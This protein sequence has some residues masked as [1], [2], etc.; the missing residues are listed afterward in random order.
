[1]KRNRLTSYIILLT[2]VLVASC[3]MTKDIPEGDQLFTGLKTIQWV[4]AKQSDNLIETQAELEAALATAPNGSLFGSSYYRLPFSFGV[5]VWNKYAEKD[6]HFAQWMTKTFGRQP[7]LMSWVNPELRASVAQNVLRNHGY[8]HGNVT[9]EAI[10]QKNPKTAKI[11]YNVSF[12]SK[13]GVMKSYIDNGKN[14][15]IS[16]DGK[17]SYSVKTKSGNLDVALI[18]N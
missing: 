18:T 11:G 14:N 7:V 9:H 16:G 5:S 4:D 17:Y 15:Y 10:Q 1:M 13:Q 6:S 8:F 3:S 12:E 2:S